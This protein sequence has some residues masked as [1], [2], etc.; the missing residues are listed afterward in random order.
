MAPYGTWSCSHGS[1]C[2]K[3]HSPVAHGSYCPT[4][5][6]PVAHRRCCPKVHGPVAHGRYCPTGLSAPCGCYRAYGANHMAYGAMGLWAYHIMAY[7]MAYRAM[8]LSH[9]L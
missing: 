3:V 4:V 7:H 6:G 9:G 8:G 2:P 5:H 1:Y